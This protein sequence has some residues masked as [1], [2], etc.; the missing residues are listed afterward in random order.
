[1]KYEIR[2]MWQAVLEDAA[3][4]GVLLPDEN[5]ESKP[6]SVLKD[7]PFL[8]VPHFEGEDPDVTQFRESWWIEP[9]VTIELTLKELLNQVPKKR[10]RADAYRHL[11]KVLREDYDIDLII[12]NKRNYEN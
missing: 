8:E 10:R 5:A 1:M 6:Q 12:K 3:A 7:R 11:Q 9:G 2:K 4:K